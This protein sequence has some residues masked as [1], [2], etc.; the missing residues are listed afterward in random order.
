MTIG[1]AASGPWAGAGVLA[2]LQA[3]EMVGRGAIGGF[4]GLAVLT[5]DRRL[6]RAETQKGGTHGLFPEA[7]PDEILTAPLAAL[8][9]SGPDRP[10]PLS[11]FVAGD[12]DVGLVTGHRFPQTIKRD[13]QPLNGT[14]LEAM[15]RGSSPQRAVDDVIDETPEFDAGFIALSA[16]G[17]FGIGNMPSVLR[18]SDQGAVQSSCSETGSAA[19]A[20]HN[21]IQPHKA[22][23]LLAC[24]TVL[25][26]MRL[27]GTA[28]STITLKAG[29]HL[30]YGAAPEIHVDIAGFVI[31]IDHPD[32]RDLQN[33]KSFGMGDRV[34]VK[35]DGRVIGWLAQE[36]FMVVRNNKIVTL[37]GKTSLDLPVF[38]TAVTE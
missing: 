36:P 20:I 33:E 30:S 22:I 11:Q 38:S 2:G 6:V 31:G 1:I 10:T 5:L 17:A 7:T 16:Q 8:I 35:Q 9:S 32:A 29:L 25:D 26:A 13:G 28:Q 27:R 3:V 18:R 12:A 34:C 14:I 15:R 21:A 37:D 19:A 4:V 23:G 24:E